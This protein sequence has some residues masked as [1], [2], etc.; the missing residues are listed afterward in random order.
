MMTYHH[1]TDL[2]ELVDRHEDWNEQQTMKIWLEDVERHSLKEEVTHETYFF[3][4]GGYS[5][6]Y[7]IDHAMQVHGL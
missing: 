6:L 1:W 7:A 4:Q 2:T 3:L 5:L